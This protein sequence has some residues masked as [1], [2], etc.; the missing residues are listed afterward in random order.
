VTNEN[1]IPSAA[2]TNTSNDVQAFYNAHPYPPPVLDLDGY[3]ASWQDENRRRVDFHLFWPAEPYREDLQILVAG[4]GT[5]QAAR[6]ALRY[7]STR[8]IGI[9]FSATSIHHSEELKRQYN[10]NNLELHQLPVV[11]V[12]ELQMEFDQIVCTGVLH[13]L[14]D[15][16]AGLCALRDT[17]KPGGA[18]H[19]MVYAPYGRTG[20][21]MLQEYC[22]QLRI[23]PSETE[24]QDLAD[25]LMA[26][27]RDHPLAHLLGQA[28][29]F[30]TK[31]GLAD[32]LLNPQDRAYTV[33]QLFEFISAAGLRFGRWLRQAPYL[34]QCGAIA[35]TPHASR[36][37]QLP[38][39]EQ[40]A[41][42]ELLRGT[43]L[44]HS[45][46]IYP[47]NSPVDQ[48]SVRFD[49]DQWQD[50]IPIR[51]PGSIVVQ[52]NLPPGTAAVLINQNHTYQDLVL[53]VDK[54]QKQIYDA[55]DGQRSISQIMNSVFM[56]GYPEQRSTDT[57]SFFQKLW[58]YDQVVLDASAAASSPST[59]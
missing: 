37:A 23:R 51:S 9:D 53:P 52:E 56:A 13:H 25:T 12:S 49:H 17:L 43:M 54:F 41:A 16:D 28:P 15:P 27:P 46:V 44:R 35:E 26:L 4:C 22:R 20:I 47:A 21:Y 7:P 59:A 57:R 31:A 2:S 3:R 34:P 42:L 38:P 30:R 1:E 45:A 33:P 32:A 40:H 36:L 58:W 39:Q 48:H 5:S 14:P 11:R 50:Y 10:L 8:V 29:D 19:L 24:I 6:Y 55:I 18:M